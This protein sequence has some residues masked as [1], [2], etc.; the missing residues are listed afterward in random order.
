MKFSKI[1][2]QQIVEKDFNY[3]SRKIRS[4]KDIVEFIFKY[5]IINSDNINTANNEEILSLQN[6]ILEQ[7][8]KRHVKIGG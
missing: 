8:R 2:L 7:M 5:Q 3:N 6:T 4:S 1:K